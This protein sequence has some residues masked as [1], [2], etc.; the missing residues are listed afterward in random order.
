[1]D[2]NFIYFYVNNYL[3]HNVSEETKKKLCQ[4]KFISKYEELLKINFNIYY[5]FL[6]DRP[7]FLRGL[8]LTHKGYPILSYY[9]FKKAPLKNCKYYDKLK[10]GDAI[11]IT[12]ILDLNCSSFCDAA[13]E[14]NKYNIKIINIGLKARFNHDD[15]HNFT[16]SKIMTNRVIKMFN[17][18][19]NIKEIKEINMYINNDNSYY[20]ITVVNYHIKYICDVISNKFKNLEKLHIFNLYDSYAR[21]SKTYDQ[22]VNIINK[23]YKLIIIKIPTIK[24][25][26]YITSSDALNSKC[27]NKYNSIITIRDKIYN[28]NL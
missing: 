26:E 18:I 24:H 11:R 4:N 23:I 16:K 17:K 8:C 15:L 22:E 28:Y 14:I 27:I 5:Q 10:D 25:M 13:K 19:K 1:M 20:A 6:M 9:K 21:F 7:K 3:K 2:T 12:N